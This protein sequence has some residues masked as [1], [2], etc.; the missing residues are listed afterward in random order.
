[1]LIKRMVIGVINAITTLLLLA[2]WLHLFCTFSYYFSGKL[3]IFYVALPFIIAIFIYC[4]FKL[5]ASTR[6]GFFR[7]L[8]V[9]IPVSMITCL[10][11][12]YIVGVLVDNLRH[13]GAILVFIVSVPVGA[14]IGG[15]IG[16]IRFKKAERKD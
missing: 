6:F 12:G 14:I 3:T 1:M 8:F 11:V 5:Y 7:Y 9:W 4:R 2:I 15:I 13:G 10:I 16:Y